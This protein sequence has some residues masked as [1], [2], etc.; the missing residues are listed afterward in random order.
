[1]VSDLYSKLVIVISGPPGSGKTT[2]AKMLA[3]KYGLR[4]LSAGLMFRE[5]AKRMGVSLMEL[6]KMAERDHSIDK[7]IDSMVVEEARKGGVVVEGHLTA[8]MLKDIAHIR[9][10]L[11]A[12]VKERARRIASREGRDVDEVMRE[13]ID[14]EESNRRR[15]MMIYGIDISDLSIFDMVLDTTSIDVN[16]V[17][18]IVSSLVEEWVRCNADRLK[19]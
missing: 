8:W 15:Y 6:Q 5:L 4:F 2:I 10:Y 11:N 17:F 1:M 18:K 12:D 3:E 14:R 13:I 7:K 19:R 9:I 16:G